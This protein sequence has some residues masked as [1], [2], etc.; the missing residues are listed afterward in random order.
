MT[1][2]RRVHPISFRSILIGFLLIPVDALWV[3][4]RGGDGILSLLVPPV[5]TTFWLVGVNALV[6]KVKPRWALRE[7]ELAVVYAML[8]VATG[9]A[10]EWMYNVTPLIGFHTWFNTPRTNYDEEIVRYLPR[11][12]VITD[13]KVLYD[14]YN[15]RTT[16]FVWHHILP[17]VKPM[18]AWGAI[19]FIVVFMMLCINSLMREQWT[20]NERLT[21]PIAQLPMALT[22]NG[23]ASP[24]WKNRL[25]W[26]GFAFGFVYDIYGGLIVQFPWLPDFRLRKPP[27]IDSYVNVFFPD[28]PW[29]NI[30]WTPLDIFPF[31]VALA[32][33][34]PL[35]LAF[36]SWFFF[37]FR[38]AQQIIASAY[39]Y[40][41]PLW[42]GMFGNPSPPFL[43]EQSWGAFIALFLISMWNSRHYLK[44]VWCDILS[45]KS[46]SQSPDL[47]HPRWALAGLVGGF[48]ALAY[49]AS[50][51]KFSIPFLLWYFSM[52]ILL[53]VIITRIRAELGPPI[54]EMAHMTTNRFFV[55]V[56]GTTYF[57]RREGTILGMLIFMN[58]L[59]RSHPMPNQ[60]EGIKLG[61]RSHAINWR[62]FLALT[63]AIAGGIAFGFYAYLHRGYRVGGHTRQWLGNE[64][65]RII[66]DWRNNP[67]TT[68]WFGVAY[69]IAG[70]AFTYFLAQMRYRL[71]WWPF[72]PAGYALCMNFG[73][74]YIWFCVFIAWL[75]KLFMLR[76][77]GHKLYRRFIPMAFGIIL[78]EYSAG[79]IWSWLAIVFPDKTWY[80][81]SIN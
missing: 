16:L 21:F 11:S 65:T 79:A 27:F 33:F 56:L 9:I 81:F 49:F 40:H 74:D 67:K 3:A 46:S 26:A 55:D 10:S 12:M 38:K 18:L 28:R 32:Y 78:G 45:G 70:A 30:G 80:S 43:T 50:L 53:G 47:I 61:E 59:Y 7:G 51:V 41:G 13:P 75:I 66:L 63:L 73:I 72:H 68:D 25:L 8:A 64:T 39:G 14:Y 22:E 19:I 76:Y 5:V 54:H 15:G 71:A 4:Y 1:Q 17:W 69:I 37:L 29:S 60:L 20:Q 48:I 2:Q 31:M 77:G 62:F 42:Q 52:F 6:R 58:R 35:D 34:L 44:R 36:S 57:A 23:G 24:V